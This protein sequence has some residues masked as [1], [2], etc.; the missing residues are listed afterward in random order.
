MRSGS[1]PDASPGLPVD[2]AEQVA[3]APVPGPA[4]VPGEDVQALQRLRQGGTDGEAV[5]GLHRSPGWAR[6]RGTEAG[7]PQF[8]RYALARAGSV[9]DFGEFPVRRVGTPSRVAALKGSRAFQVRSA[10]GASALHHLRAAGRRGRRSDR[11]SFAPTAV[12]ATRRQYGPCPAQCMAVISR[13]RCWSTGGRGPQRCPNPPSWRPGRSPAG[14][15]CWR[16]P[17]CSRGRAC[18][19]ARRRPACWPTTRRG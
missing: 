13:W 2:G 11:P 19:A 15:A 6:R 10:A 4:Q 7:S 18:R 5:D 1:Q 17:S 9:K 12:T 14:T 3:R 16:T 8:A